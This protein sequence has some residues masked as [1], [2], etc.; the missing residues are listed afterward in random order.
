MKCLKCNAERNLQDLQCPECGVF[1][2]KYEAYLEKKAIEDKADIEK[3]LKRLEELEC[4]EQERANNEETTKE[5]D[6]DENS[7]SFL[8]KTAFVISWFLGGIIAIKGISLIFFSILMG[9]LYII[10][11]LFVIPPC[12]Q[13]LNTKFKL[14][15]TIPARI[16][17]VIMIIIF[18][19][20]IG[21]YVENKIFE[22]ESE[23]ARIASAEAEKK[24]YD[25]MTPEQR[26]QI[27]AEKER[28]ALKA[29]QEAEYAAS[30]AKIAQYMTETQAKVEIEKKAY[31]A[32]QIASEYNQN[33]VKADTDWKGHR[34]YV[35]GEIADI[36]TDFTGNAYVTLR[37]GVNEFMEPQFSFKES[38]KAKVSELR[39]GQEVIL[40]CTGNGDI[41]K[42]P[43]SKDCL[44]VQ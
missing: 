7:K 28:K 24:A 17:M 11:S 43:M 42:T 26:A 3:K 32:Y 44:F 39:K 2:A 10:A 36:N 16:G 13:F 20:G 15:G 29:K 21:I 25:A 12:W 8:Q 5:S 19:Q 4:K 9:L 34:Y 33:T 37:G 23:K 38:E 1:Y 6:I 18:G 40:E 22:E 30:Q 14:E 41:A 35:K 31:S 27:E